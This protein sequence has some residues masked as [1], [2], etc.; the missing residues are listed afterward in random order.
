MLNQLKKM[1]PDLKI[2]SVE[3]A[4]FAS[5]GKIIRTIDATEIIHA[6][7]NIPNPAEGSMYVPTEEQFESLEAT[8]A[9]KDLCF[10]GLPTEVGYCWGRNTLMNATEWHK[11][12]EINIAITG[13]VLILGHIWDV[14]NGKIDSSRFTVFYVPEGTV[15]EVYATSLHFCPCQ[16]QDGGFGCVVALPEG[17]NTLLDEASADPLLF[18]KNKWLIAHEENSGLI[19][20]GVV[21]GITGKNIE[22]RY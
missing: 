7:K 9:L 15:L 3:S 18:K 16:I 8:K 6:A 12:G 19:G 21:A 14:Q 11:S 17:T 20:R 10:G 22:I 1:N 2:Y 13:F 5:F 4:K